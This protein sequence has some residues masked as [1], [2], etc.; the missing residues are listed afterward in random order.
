MSIV[1]SVLA[2]LAFLLAWPVPAALSRFR[3][4]PISKVILW[5]AVGLSGGLTYRYGFGLRRGSGLAQPV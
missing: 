4:D 3:G 5:Q 1:G 2:V